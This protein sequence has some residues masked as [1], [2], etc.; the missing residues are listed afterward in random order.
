MEYIN[1]RK[2]GS[3]ATL[4]EQKIL[5]TTTLIRAGLSVVKDHHSPPSQWA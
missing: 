5:A 4:A 3:F 2:S 1:R